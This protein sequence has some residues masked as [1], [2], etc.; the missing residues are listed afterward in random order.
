MNLSSHISFFNTKSRYPRQVV[1]ANWFERMQA[2]EE[3]VNLFCW[4]RSIDKQ[5]VDYLEKCVHKGV[6]SISFSTTM[7]ELPANMSRIRTKWDPDHRL[8]A[9][10]FWIDVYRLVNDFLAFSESASGK[11]HLKVV[12]DNA[13]TKFHTDGYRLRLFTTYVGRGTEWL[14]EDAVNRTAL[15]THNKNIFK[16]EFRIQR[17]KTGH[18]SILKG[19]APNQPQSVRGI[20]HRSPQINDTGEKRIILRVDI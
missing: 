11:V 9:D 7:E 2:L 15:G 17:I 1:S 5:I 3:D 6:E 14:P 16:N 13:C 4:K 18:V 12:G 20:V 10:A 19:E 8:D